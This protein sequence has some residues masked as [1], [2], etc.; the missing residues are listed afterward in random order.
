MN[1][2]C[3]FV[4]SFSKIPSQVVFY[5]YVKVAVYIKK[6][7]RQSVRLSSFPLPPTRRLTPSASLRYAVAFL[8]ESQ[9]QERERERE[10][11]TE[12]ELRDVSAQYDLRYGGE[13]WLTTSDSPPNI[14]S[15][16]CFKSERKGP[17]LRSFHQ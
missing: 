13:R 16:I 12:S 7:A 11:V 8:E 3:I 10:R 9:K 17:H 6:T 1:I 15:G 4:K 5:Y 2:K 14:C